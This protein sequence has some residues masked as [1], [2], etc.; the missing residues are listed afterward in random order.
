M[1][2][3]ESQVYRPGDEV[4]ASGIYRVTHNPA[5]TEE[6]DIIGVRKKHFPPCNTCEHPRFV[7]IHAAHHIES[8]EHFR[9]WGHKV[10]AE[11][12]A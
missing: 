7:L 5:H 9:K 11:R 3:K 12:S 4:P 1:T 8:S 6:H 10:P 2:K